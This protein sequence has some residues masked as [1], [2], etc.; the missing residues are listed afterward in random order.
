MLRKIEQ[1]FENLGSYLRSPYIF[2]LFVV[3]VLTMVVFGVNVY[4][5][6]TLL[7]IVTILVFIAVAVVVLNGYLKLAK[8]SHE[9]ESKNTEFQAATRNLKDGVIIYSPDFEILN[10]NQ[11]AEEITETRAEEVVGKKITPQS[12]KDPK[13]KII[14]QVLFPT[15]APTATDLSK[16][17]WPQIVR[18]ETEN[19][20]L[21]LHTIL[22]RLIDD[23]KK[24]VGFIKVVRDETRERGIVESK[25]EFVSVAAHQLRTPLT[26]LSWSLES[27][28]ESL[29][30]KPEIQEQLKASS[31]L[32]ERMIKI[33]NDLLD[34]AKIEEGKF[35][36]K[37]EDVELSEFISQIIS[38]V[39][40]IATGYGINVRFDDRKKKYG[41]RI[42]S[43]RLG[44]VLSNI[45]DNAIR[46]NT[47]DGNVTI[48]LEEVLN[49]GRFVKIRIA[50]TGIGI[51]EEELGHTFE[52][53]HR[54]QNAIQTEPNGSGL[55]LYIAKN[56]V[57]RHGGE[58]GVESTLG[59]G[60]TFWF[61]LPLD[62]VLVP[63]KGVV[64][65]E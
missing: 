56:I 40:P 3:F 11:A 36:Y 39:E 44:M 8:L 42:D 50:D 65:E 62:K 32:T 15:L 47:K 23:R 6:P 31:D 27:L 55:G 24:T 46:Y 52:K 18:I 37:F 9:I 43:S 20:P 58:I 26:A 10:L 29:K 38:H 51:P 45:L 34:V 5:A 63:E 1:I 49:G 60:T 16:D 4:F 19:P 30:D 21:K 53:F 33:V 22:D 2:S 57:K 14:T 25:G 35:G 28:N 48:T 12:M 7:V 41:V 59:R 64:Y 13:L 61:T 17:S 54:S